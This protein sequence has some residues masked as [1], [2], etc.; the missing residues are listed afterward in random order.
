[1]CIRDRIFE[2]VGGGSEER[3][4]A[5]QRMR[6]HCCG[7]RCHHDGADVADRERTQDHLEGEHHPGDRGVEARADPSTR[8]C[9]NETLHLVETK[10][11]VSPEP[12]AECGADENDG[13]LS[14]AGTACPEGCSGGVT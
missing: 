3:L 9:R 5:D 10:P 2:L 1:M 6:R 14:S 11:C 4:T 13:A 7:H 12:R 8:P